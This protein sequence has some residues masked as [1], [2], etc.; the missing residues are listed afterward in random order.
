MAE[1]NYKLPFGIG[2]F[3]Y[4]ICGPKVPLKNNIGPLDP[5]SCPQ[6]YSLTSIDV[7]GLRPTLKTKKISAVLYNMQYLADENGT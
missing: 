4:F 7:Q 2:T 3:V 1:S 6:L 5:T